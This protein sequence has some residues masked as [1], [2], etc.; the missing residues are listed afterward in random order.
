MESPS[1]K[2]QWFGGGRDYA[3]IHSIIVDPDD[4]DHIYTGISVAGLFESKD[5]GNT[6]NPMNKGLKADFL[7]DPHAEIGHDPHLLVSAPSD[8]TIMWQQNHCGVF[9]SRDACLNWQDVSE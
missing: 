7:P 2:D 1:R 3:G 5:C 9:I 6:W 8:K 4:S